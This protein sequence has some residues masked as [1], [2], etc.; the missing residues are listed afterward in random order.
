MLSKKLKVPSSFMI[1]V[2]CEHKISFF[3]VVAVV[4]VVVFLLERMLACHYLY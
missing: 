1:F 3:T 2:W 4:V